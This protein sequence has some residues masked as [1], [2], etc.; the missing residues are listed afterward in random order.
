MGGGNLAMS[1]AR[2]CVDI[3]LLA[4]HTVVAGGKKTSHFIPVDFLKINEKPAILN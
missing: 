3:Q 1:N 2:G 4:G